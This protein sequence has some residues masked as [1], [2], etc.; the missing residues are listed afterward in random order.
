MQCLCHVDYQRYLHI[1][2]A[3]A[4]SAWL[5]GAITLR[6]MPLFLFNLRIHRDSFAECVPMCSGRTYFSYDFPMKYTAPYQVDLICCLFW[7]TTLEHHKNSPIW[8]VVQKKWYRSWCKI[9]SHIDKY[10][11]LILFT[12]L[13]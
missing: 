9:T 5:Y 13:L 10:S 12:I 2:E 8:Y 1:D 3:Q 6:W 7:M 11:C 4:C